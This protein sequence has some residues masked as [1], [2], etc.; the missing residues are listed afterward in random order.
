MKTTQITPIE[1]QARMKAGDKL[2][3][4]DVRETQE[5]R[6]A[7]IGGIHIPLGELSNR[8]TELS[9]GDEI[10]CLCHHGVRS[11]H[12]AGFLR[13]QGFEKVLNLRGGIDAWSAEVDAGVKRY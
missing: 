8:F 3:I 6:I 2:T 10:I 13:Q 11:A 4:L 7:S 5:I 9:P 1:L 12:A